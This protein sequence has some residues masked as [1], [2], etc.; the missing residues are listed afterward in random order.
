VQRVLQ[1]EPL[2]VQRDM[3][4]VLGRKNMR[5]QSGSGET[6]LD[7][8]R[9]RGGVELDRSTLAGWVGASSQLLAPLVEAI[10]R[11]VKSAS[12]IHADDTPVPVLSPGR[13]RTK[14]TK[15]SYLFVD[16]G[17]FCAIDENIRRDHAGEWNSL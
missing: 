7:R 17:V 13:G 15:A 14:I 12:K 5:Q 8:T 2:P 11:H 6:P 9:R 4:G 10:R 1:K 16:D 3:V